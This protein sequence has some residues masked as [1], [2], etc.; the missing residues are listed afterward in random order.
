MSKNTPVRLYG[1]DMQLLRVVYDLGPAA[2][3]ELLGY[4]ADRG[5]FG[6]TYVADHPPLCRA[7]ALRHR[8]RRAMPRKIAPNKPALRSR[9]PR[10]R[11][12]P[13]T[14]QFSTSRSIARRFS[15][16]ICRHRQDDDTRRD[17]THAGLHHRGPDR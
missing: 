1:P 17:R 2:V 12:R 8:G 14:K 13:H 4:V 3:A 16:R 10:S 15:R 5:K 7:E 9:S 6:P 11:P